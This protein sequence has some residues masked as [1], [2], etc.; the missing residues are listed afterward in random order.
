M[1]QILATDIG[2]GHTKFAY[3]DNLGKFPSLISHAVESYV[4]I[5]QSD[6]VLYNGEYYYVAESASD[7]PQF[8]LPNSPHFLVK[9]SPVFL[10]HIMER[11]K[12]PEISTICVS[13]SLADYKEH[14]NN[15][16]NSC[17]K[18]LINQKY[19]E[20]KI[21]VVPQG[22]GIWYYCDQPKNAAIIDIGFN[23]IDVL[24]VEDS[25][26]SVDKS[27]GLVDKG[28][29][30]LASN[31]AKIFYAK[32]NDQIS[33]YLANEIL[34]NHG[35]IKYER[36]EYDLSEDI[37]KLRANYTEK[38]LADVFNNTDFKGLLKSID[39]L[40]VAG[41]GA[42]YLDGSFIEKEGI[43]VPNK[44]DYANV[45]GF[46]KYAESKEKQY[47]IKED[48]MFG[49]VD[50]V[51]RVKIEVSEEVAEA[52]EMLNK[53]N[54]KK[55]F[56]T[57]FLNMFDSA[58]SKESYNKM[59]NFVMTSNNININNASNQTKKTNDEKLVGEFENNIMNFC[60]IKKEK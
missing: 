48:N 32:Y 16:K 60:G 2:Y 27:F 30:I 10:Y 3:G 22:V 59:L 45:L 17:S 34:L 53:V 55:L 15:L 42:Y 7:S 13:L 38:V 12:F 51:I 40:I 56:F 43:L 52:L 25:I 26:L 23:T 28:A 35:K 31:V 50:I 41:G 29:V 44:P 18:F 9:Y 6:L 58:D 4:G 19:F 20:N 54:M 21:L 24:V 57:S 47:L 37:E 33:K 39:T 5:G 49:K 46:I 36:K 14:K 11:L 8:I 1:T